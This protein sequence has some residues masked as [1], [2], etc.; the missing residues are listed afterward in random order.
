LKS[1]P[2]S[3]PRFLPPAAFAR[4]LSPNIYGILG[5]ITPFR[6]GGACSAG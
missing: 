6:G 3:V 2:I 1:R 5:K 4:P